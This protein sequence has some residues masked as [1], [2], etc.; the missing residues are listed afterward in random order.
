MKQNVPNITSALNTF[1]IE[2]LEDGVFAIAMTLLVL[3]LKIPETTD[4][5]VFHSIVKIWPN[6]LTFFGSFLL[7][8]VYWFGHRTALHYI[9][10]ADHTFH[11]LGILILM[12]VSIV[13][14]SASMIAN[15]YHDQGAIILYGLN[16]ITISLTMYWQWYYATSGYR[17]ID[18][19]LPAYVIRFAKNRFIFAPI[20][21]LLAICFSLVNS[22]IPLILYTILPVFYILPF[23]V[24]VWEKIAKYQVSRRS[25]RQSSI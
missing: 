12:F 13:P 17:L 24:Q 21:Y 19:D 10:N 16:L 22:V 14:F 15:Y 9:K 3:N 5:S 6:L 4:Q 11:W 20:A 8:G 7:L 25:H 23:F 18:K 1:R 2:T